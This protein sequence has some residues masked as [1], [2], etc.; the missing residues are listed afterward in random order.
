MRRTTLAFSAVASIAVVATSL[1][2]SAATSAIAVKQI[3]YRHGGSGGDSDLWTMNADGSGKVALPK[4]NNKR[5]TT[6]NSSSGD[7]N[8]WMSP[9]GRW[10]AFGSDRTGKQHVFVADLTTGTVQDVTPT[11]TVAVAPVGW[12]IDESGAQRVV[13]VTG[14]SPSPYQLMSVRY[15]GAG[16]RAVTANAVPMGRSDIT[17]DGH[18][19]VAGDFD[20]SGVRRIW[21]ATISTTPLANSAFSAVT[22]PPAGNDDNSPAWVPNSGALTFARGPS[23]SN[24]SAIYLLP[25]GGDE[26]T[27][28]ATKIIE[29]GVE[30]GIPMYSRDSRQM[31]YSATSD[32]NALHYQIWVVQTDPATGAPVKPGDSGVQAT[33]GSYGDWQGTWR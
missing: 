9:D 16:T 11:T 15:D 20:G 10:L 6:I 3:V 18:I 33:S 23:S 28:P 21:T 4:S 19:A 30:S 22:S 1:P 32:G 25:A 31:D 14:V 8:P 27:T 17:V 2:S 13:Y 26:R 5:A 29:Q 7:G 24:A 12:Y